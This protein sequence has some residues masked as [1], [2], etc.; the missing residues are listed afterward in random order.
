MLKEDLANTRF[1]KKSKK[2]S[3]KGELRYSLWIF[4][5]YRRLADGHK[6]IAA[7]LN[8]LLRKGEPSTLVDLKEDQT[9]A[10]TVLI[11]NITTPQVLELPLMGLQYS[12]D[13]ETSDSGVDVFNYIQLGKG[14]T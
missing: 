13:T 10:F 11:N 5:I 7:P 2:L 12:L 3:N 8:N 14:S 9:S 6:Y 4:N 1:F